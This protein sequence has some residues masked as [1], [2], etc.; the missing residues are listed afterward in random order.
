MKKQLLMKPEKCTGCRSCEIICS[1]NRGKSF[2]PKNSAVSVMSYEEAM[3]SV[4]VMCLQ[5][6]Q[7]ACISACPVGAMYRDKD[8]T[9]KNNSAKCIVCKL[10]VGACPLGNVTFSAA[11]K[12]IV[13]CELCG[14]D[15]LCAKYCP[16]GCLVYS[17]EADLLGR[18]KAI[19]L[20]LKN[21]YG[22][23]EAKQ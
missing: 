11:E 19:G 6:E 14:G 16:S 22:Q 3:V 21:V 5:C 8:G 23:E 12:K 13:K 2:N 9:V 18:K 7:A 4:P 15:P 1:F 10:C 17:D 20:A